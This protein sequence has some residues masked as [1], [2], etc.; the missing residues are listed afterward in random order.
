MA[1]QYLNDI[2]LNK[3]QLSQAVIE[4][5]ANDAGVGQDPREGQIYFNTTSDKLR[6]YTE[7]GWINVDSVVTYDLATADTGTAITLTGSDST[8]DSITISGTSSEVEVTRQSGTE[9]RI[10]LPDDVTIS[11]QLVV[12]NTS[13][14]QVPVIHSKTGGTGTNL[15]LESQNTGTGSGPNIELYRNAGIPQDGDNL[16]ILSFRTRNQS[17]VQPVT[18]GNIKSVIKDASNDHA[19]MFFG[20]NRGVE[21]GNVMALHRNGNAADKGAVVINP[22][23]ETTIPSEALY[24]YGSSTFEG[25]TTVDGSLLVEGN[26]TVSGTTTT[27][28][29]ETINLADNIVTL[30]SNAT[31]T[32]TEDAG[33]EV[34]RGDETNVSL[35]WDESAD[36]WTFTNNGS[37]FYNIPVPSEYDNFFFQVGVAGNFQEVSNGGLISFNQGGG[38]TVGISGD[39]SITY[40]HADTS[41][42]NS[43]TNY[44]LN[45]IQS[46][47]LDDYGHVTSLD[48]LDITSGVNTLIDTKIN[49]TGYAD[50]ITDTDTITHGLDT[51]DVIIQLY[52]ENTYETV[53]ADVDRISDTQATITF[54]STPTNSVRVLV[55]KIS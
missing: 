53:Y 28:N 41:S 39:D 6:V 55:Q 14:T 29:T 12:G 43:V 42:Q 16:G 10:G 3:N 15:L 38:L 8:A 37:T 51:R 25:F 48:S 5:Q 18:Y 36:R 32:P 47:G 1:I 33:I 30:N 4:N 45:V 20:L 21:F 31:G 19:S 26:L 7:A 52:D 49:A 22:P 17:D 35:I 40:S 13:E 9:L 2:N 50:T 44:S 34:E 54:A 46:V 27:V 11:S 24:V 23:D